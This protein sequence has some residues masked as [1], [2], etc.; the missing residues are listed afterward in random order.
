[1]IPGTTDR[2]TY[3]V[4]MQRAGFSGELEFE[5][6]RDSERGCHLEIPGV[7]PDSRPWRPEQEA[8]INENLAGELRRVIQDRGDAWGFSSPEAAAEVE[9]RFRETGRLLRR[10]AQAR[11]QTAAALLLAHSRS[12]AASEELDWILN[13]LPSAEKDFRYAKLT[14]LSRPG[15]DF[16]AAWCACYGQDMGTV[17]PSAWLR[18][19]VADVR[20]EA[21]PREDEARRPMPGFLLTRQGYR[22]LIAAALLIPGKWLDSF[23]AVWTY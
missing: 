15:K 21:P 22:D 16:Y 10:I 13:G 6:V 19:T 8:W 9:D 5:L 3:L 11:T 20:E 17:R 14:L 7:G 18:S 12:H 23:T 2:K 4:R 1:M